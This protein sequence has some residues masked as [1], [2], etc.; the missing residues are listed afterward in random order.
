MDLAK[1]VFH[2]SSRGCLVRALRI[3]LVLPQPGPGSHRLSAARASSAHPYHQSSDNNIVTSLQNF[4]IQ[5]K[6]SYLLSTPT[7]IGDGK[8]M[9]V[10]AQESAH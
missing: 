10:T 9:T 3:I 2:C 1:T 7:S 5:S 4:K 8:S 6:I